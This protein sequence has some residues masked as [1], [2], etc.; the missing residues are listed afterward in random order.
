MDTHYTLKR[1]VC[2]ISADG[3]MMQAANGQQVTPIVCQPYR[4]PIVI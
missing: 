3:D 2:V 4:C 1:S